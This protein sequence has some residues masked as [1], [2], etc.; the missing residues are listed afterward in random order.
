[1]DSF[2]D[3][4]KMEGKTI[5]CAKY[6]DIEGNDGIGIIFKDNTYV[7]IEAYIHYSEGEVKLVEKIHDLTKLDLGVITKEEYKE[8]DKSYNEKLKMSVKKQEL[9]LLEELKQ[10]YENKKGDQK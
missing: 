7:V 4:Q 3:V 9:K 2:T 8:L 1:M 6:V 5:K 10:K